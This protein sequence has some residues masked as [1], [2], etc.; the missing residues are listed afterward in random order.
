MNSSTTT[1]NNTKIQHND[2][3]LTHKDE[4]ACRQIISKKKH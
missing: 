1:E 2:E 3:E 4:L